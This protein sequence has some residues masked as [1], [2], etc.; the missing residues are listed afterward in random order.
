MSRASELESMREL[1]AIATGG[2]LDATLQLGNRYA[3]RRYGGLSEHEASAFVRHLF[4]ASRPTRLNEMYAFQEFT[5]S[6]R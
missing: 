3:Q 6:M 4:Q 2:Y 1:R 5:P